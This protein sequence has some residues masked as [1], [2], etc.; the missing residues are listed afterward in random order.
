MGIIDRGRNIICNL[1]C[2][3]IN[4]NIKATSRDGTARLWEC[5]SQT[6]ISIIG[7]IDK[8]INSCY[9]CKNTFLSH[10]SDIERKIG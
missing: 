5:A 8:P 4:I 3:I 1:L 10:F 9:I 2:F 6:T 7:K